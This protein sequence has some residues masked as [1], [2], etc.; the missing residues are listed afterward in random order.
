MDNL[1]G[2]VALVTGSAGGIGLGIARAC[3]AAGM[4]VVLSDIDE[5][6]LAE[7]AAVLRESGA[8]V[9]AFLL[10]VTDRE[11]WARAAREVPAAMGPVQ[12]LVNNAGV[13]TLGLPF[14]EIGPAMWDRVVAINLTGAYNGVHY[15]AEGMRAAGAGH[16]V[17]TS[18]A[19][20][21]LGFPLLAP[22]S[23][24]KFALIGFS[25]SLRAEF[26]DDGIGVTVLCPGSVRSRLWRTSRPVRGLPDTDTPP[27]DISAQTARAT[28][29]PYEVGRRTL[30]A[31]VA[32]EPYV[33][34][35]PEY[36][37]AVIERH[38]RLLHAFDVA[39]AFES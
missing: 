24:T 20:G 5:K 34:T 2:K 4:K 6:T 31:V 26:A 33:F 39:A 23:T 17:N 30:A 21:L 10:D 13:S 32:D 9:M 11:A 1:A 16:I 8:D 35:H 22:Y 38:E 12:L 3:A 19:G 7:S 27:D 36:R 37:S 29:E 15:F 14:A 28:M 18:S 25:E